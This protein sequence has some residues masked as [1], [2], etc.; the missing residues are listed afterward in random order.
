[1]KMSFLKSRKSCQKRNDGSLI[2]NVSSPGHDQP[3]DLTSALPRT[4]MPEAR[5]EKRR[6]GAW[7]II[8]LRDSSG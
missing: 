2:P 8:N 7:R 3:F 4:E 1:M 6:T 5:E